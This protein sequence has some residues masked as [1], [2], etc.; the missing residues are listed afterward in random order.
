[1]AWGDASLDALGGYSLDM[2]FW[3]CY[4][5]PDTIFKQTLHHIKNGKKGNLI[6]I[7]KLEYATVLLNYAATISFWCTRCKNYTGYQVPNCSPPSRQ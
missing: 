7:N 3:W 5:L 1:M 2:G 6:S 4:Q